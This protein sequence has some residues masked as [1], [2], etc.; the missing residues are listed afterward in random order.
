MN[1]AVKLPAL[2][3]T[4]PLSCRA[5]PP[6]QELERLRGELLALRERAGE[7]AAIRDQLGQERRLTESLQQRLA[8]AQQS[9]LEARQQAAGRLA[10]AAAELRAGREETTRRTAA[11]EGAAAEARARV[12]QL[13]EEA[14]NLRD[15]VK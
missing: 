7:L 2:L 1:D 14:Q 11:A 3:S 8:G 13:A 5:A 4:W 6:T 12:E 10:E 9:L 15:A